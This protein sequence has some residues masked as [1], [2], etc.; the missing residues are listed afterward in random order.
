M[1]NWPPPKTDLTPN[2]SWIDPHLK[3]LESY[4]SSYVLEPFYWFCLLSCL[5]SEPQLK[6]NWLSGY[7]NHH[8]PANIMPLLIWAP[9]ATFISFLSKVFCI[10]GQKIAKKDHRRLFVLFKFQKDGS[11]L[12]VHIT[13]PTI[14]ETIFEN[15][16]YISPMKVGIIQ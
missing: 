7:L 8:I 2:S 11:V 15:P 5:E 14:M 4:I 6:L 3:L 1:L 9:C 16:K 10:G 13:V 12:F